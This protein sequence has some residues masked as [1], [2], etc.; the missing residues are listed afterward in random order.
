MRGRTRPRGVGARLRTVDPL[1]P[2]VCAVALGVYLV[3]GLDGYLTRDIGLY[4]Y[5][6]QQFAE[7]VPPYV[8]VLNRAGPLAHLMPG[9]GAVAARLVGVDEVLGMRVLFLLITVG[10]VGAA[11]LLGRDVLRSRAAGIACAA[12]LL[13]FHGVLTYATYGPREKTPLLLFL[14]LALLATAHQR[15]ATTGVLIALATL[16]WQPAFFPAIAGAVTAVLIGRGSGGIKALVRLAAGGL[17]PPA[18]FVVVYAA[19]GHLRL[20]LDDFLLIN[21]RYT[22]QL[23]YLDDVPMLRAVV[24]KGFGWTQWVFVVGALVIPLATTIA[25]ARR[26]T[27]RDPGTAVLAGATVALLAGWWWSAKAFNGWADLFFLLPTAALGVGCLAAAV[28]RRVSPRAGMATALAWAVAS[29]GLTVQ[30]AVQTRDHQLDTQRA[31][32]DA[33]LHALPR[34]DRQILSVSAPQP[35][36]LAHQRNPSRFQL[37]GNG[38]IEYLDDTWPGGHV[39]FAAWIGEERPA[40]V[41]YGEV[42]VKAFTKPTLD[43]SYTCVGRSP[44]WYW[45]LRSDLGRQTLKA[46]RTSLTDHTCPDDEDAG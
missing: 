27:R 38:V 32:V 15:W 28:G 16:T 8:A 36:V 40:V 41:A 13:S 18:L 34:G 11:Y 9:I 6:G 12:A 25:V 33:V 21:L 45:Y 29:A 10:C 23:T 14:L 26:T 24:D 2:V 43:A 37:F 17:V 44:G 31:D 22:E 46:A 30:Y 35:L 39:G 19:I 5:A 1:L 7:G 20:L 3:H 4:S 42:G